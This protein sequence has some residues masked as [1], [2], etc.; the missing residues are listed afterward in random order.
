[1]NSIELLHDQIVFG[2]SYGTYIRHPNYHQRIGVYLEHLT[3]LDNGWTDYTLGKI[4]QSGPYGYIISKSNGFSRYEFFGLRKAYTKE[5][6]FVDQALVRSHDDLVWININTQIMDINIYK[7]QRK[8][9]NG[10]TKSLFIEWLKC[11]ILRY[12]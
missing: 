4:K 9:I 6:G 10:N 8:V 2:K 7:P 5:A 11:S 1:M 12:W 3:D